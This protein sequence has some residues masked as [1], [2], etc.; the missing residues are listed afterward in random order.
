MDRQS[1]SLGSKKTTPH[2]GFRESCKT[3]PEV[4]QD[5]K[6]KCI[7]LFARAELSSVWIEHTTFRLYLNF[8]LCS[9][10][11]ATTGRLVNGN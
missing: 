7:L 8:S 1:P 2:K 11:N 5:A 10:V 3:Q 4:V 6:K 9:R